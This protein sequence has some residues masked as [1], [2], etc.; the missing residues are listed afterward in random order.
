MDSRIQDLKRQF[1]ITLNVEDAKRL[2]AELRRKFPEELNIL[3]DFDLNITDQGE[4][5]T[6]SYFYGNQLQTKKNYIFVDILKFE[7][8]RQ[9]G[10]KAPRIIL[11]SPYD[12]LSYEVYA[13]DAEK[14]IS[15]MN[16][17]WIVGRFTFLRRGNYTALD[18]IGEI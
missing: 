2:V 3:S 11:N 5:I 6:R 17:G 10:S 4:V 1:N 8:I 18:Y 14:I 16:K 9:T 13:R 7:A 12:G 15:H